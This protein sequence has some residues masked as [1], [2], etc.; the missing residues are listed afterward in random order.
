[1][2][3]LNFRYH[4]EIDF[5]IP[6][7]EHRFT[8]KC[9]PYSNSVQQVE[10]LKY[11]IVPNY[12]LC[13]TKDSFENESIYGSCD[14]EHNVFSVDVWGNLKTGL[15]EKIEMRTSYEADIYKYQT[16]HTKP[17]EEVKQYSEELK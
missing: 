8:L 14:K 1:M 16:E 11:N 4:L 6:V 15:S 17:G 13:R 3:R 7:K 2:K 5:D 10:S 9:I 12:F